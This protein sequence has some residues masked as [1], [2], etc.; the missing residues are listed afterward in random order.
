MITS[1]GAGDSAERMDK[2]NDQVEADK[3]KFVAGL[4]HKDDGSLD[5]E[6]IRKL[7]EGQ[8]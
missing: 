8:G 7:A 2:V 4:P 5:A 1:G 3:E 6:A